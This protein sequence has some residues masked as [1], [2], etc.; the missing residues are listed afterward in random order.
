MLDL[1]DLDG[2]IG[3]ILNGIDANDFSGRSVSSA[4]DVNGDGYDDLIIGARNADPDG[5]SEAGET[6]LIYGGASAPGTGGALD[7][8]DLD[9]TNGFILTGI[10]DDDQ[11]GQSVSSAGDV[12]GDGYDDLI[13]GAFRADP[14]GDNDAGET[15]VIYGGA[16]GTESLTPVTAQGTAA[17][18]NFTGNAGADSFTAIAT[19]DVV[20]GGAGDDRISVTALDFAAIDGGTGQDTLVLAGADLSL[21]LREPGNGGVDSVEVID[22]SGAGGNTLVLDAQAVFDLTEER[23]GGIATLDVLGDANDTVEL[24]VANFTSSG[25]ETEDGTTYNVYQGGNAE[26]RVQTGVQVQ[27]AAAPVFTSDASAGVAENQRLAYTAVA[28]DADG[29]TLSYGL[30]G[31]DAALFTIDSTTGVVS[32]ITAPD[33]GN[34]GDAGGDNVY[35]ITVTASDG[36]H[37]TDQTVAITVTDVYELIDLS[38]LDGT[39]GFILNGID[40]GD[41][42]GYSVSSAG[43]V[44]GDGYDDLIIGARNADPNGDRDAGETYVIYGGASAPGTNGVLD[45]SDLDGTD[46][47]ILNGIYTFGNSGDSVSSAGDVNG[48]GY[49]DLI[50]QAARD[51][52]TYVVYGGANAPGTRGVLDLSALDGTN[53]FIL[54]GINAGMFPRRSVSSAGDVN[55]DGYDDLLIGASEADPNGQSSGETY[56][57][58]GRASGPGT[59]GV[60]DLSDL[61]GTNG[62]IL[63][64][65][66]AN[67][68]SGISVSSAGD[69]NGD[70]YD[71]LIIGAIGADPNGESS[72][73]TYIVYGGA[74]APGTGGVLELSDLD[75]T[76]GFTLNGI[77]Q[78][79]GSGRSV[80]STG[81][82]N[83][84]GYDDLIIGANG[85]DP[86]G[87]GSGETYVVYG[88]ASAPGTNGVLELSDLD[89]TNGFILTGIDAGDFSGSSISSAGDVNGDGYDDLIIGARNADPNGNNSGETYVVYGGASAPGTDGVL[90]LSMLNGSNG[91]ILNGIDAN[92]YSGRSVSSAGDVNGDGYDDLI[93]GARHADPNGRSSGET[94]VIYGGATGTESLTPVTAQGTAAADNFTGNAGADSFTAIATNDVV[95]GGAGDDRISVTALDFAAIDG[96][97]GQDTLVLDGAGLSLDLTGA[98]HAGVDSV[99]VFDLSGTGANTLLLDAQAVFDLTEERDGGIA[100]LDV[101]GDADDTVELTGGSFTANGTATEDGT[102]YNVYQGG[103]A[104]VRVQTG[105]QVQIAAAPVFTSDATAR[106]AENQTVAYEAQATDADSDTLSYSLYGTDAALFTIDPTTGVVSF[107]TAPDF[108]NPGDAGGDNVYDITVTASDGTNS[109]DQTVTITVTN[110]Y[111][112]VPLFSFSVLDGTNGFILNGIDAGDQS[113]RSVS[114]AGDVNGDGYDDLIIGAHRAGPNGDFGAGETYVVYGGA[115]APGTGGRFNLSTLNGTNGFI[116]NGI[117][118]GD[119]SGWSVSS[120]GDV[121]GDGY[122]DLI[123]GASYADP[124]GDRYAGETYVIYGGASAPGT[125]GRFNLSMLNGTNGFILNGIDRFD[126]SGWSVSSA[127]DVNG[128]GYDDLIIGGNWLAD[129]NGDISAGETYIVYGG[130]SAPGT[131]GVLDLG[132]L[133]GTDGFILNGIDDYDASGGSVSSAGDV[134][135]DGYDDLIIG[136]RYADPNGDNSAG[137]TYVVYGGA[138]APGT[139]GRF[140]LSTLNGTNGFILNGIDAFDG[141]GYSVS[142]AGDVNGDGYDDLIIGASSA[143][144]NGDSSAGETYIV[145]GGASAP[146]TGGRFNLSTLNG[147]NGFILNGIDAGDDSGWSVSS[148]GDVNGDGYDDLIIGARTADPNGDNA[149]GET[150]VVYGGASAP[151]TNGVLDLSD[152]DGT[153]GFIL[154]GIDR[155]DQ[156]GRSVSSAG[157]VNGDGYDDLIIGALGA[158]PN[159]ANPIGAILIGSRYVGE[160]YVIYGGATGIKSLTPVTAQGTAAA[161]NFT[162]NAGADSFT[163]IATNDVVRG[164]AGDDRISVTAL[165]FAAID[166]GTGQDT[167]LLD[168]AGLSLDLREP[169]NGRVDSVEVIDLSGA[170]GNTLLLDAQAVFD[171]TEE[172]AG[173]IATLDVLGDGDDTVVLARDNFIFDSTETEAGTT[174]TVYR[175]DNAEVRVA[176]GVEVQNPVATIDL[177][178]LNGTNGFILN[179]IDADDRSGW[180]VSSAGDVNGDGY[181]DLIIGARTA[182]PNG[183]DSGESYVVYGGASAP[184]EDGVLDLSDLDGTNGFILNGIDAGDRS[185]WSVSSAGDVNGDGYDDLIIGAYVAD[186]NGD[187]NAGETYVIYGGASAPGTGGRLNLSTLDGTDGFILNGIDADDR[188]GWSVSSAGDVNGDGYDDLIIG[189]SYADPNGDRSGE[190]YVVYGGASA[191]GTDGV[192]DLGALDGSGG[193]IL[194]GID[195]VDISGNSVSSAGDVNGDG[196]DDLIIG[197]NGADPNGDNAAGET[198]VVYGGA[199]APGTNG[200]LDLSDLDGTNGFIFN[201]IDAGDNSGRSVS[202]A[203][204]VNGDGYDDLIMGARWADPNGDNGAGETYVVYGGASAPGTNGA[205]DLSDLDGTNGFILNGIDARD[206]S[207]FSVSSAGDI[208]GDGYDDLI[209]GAYEADPGGDSDAGETYLV[210]GGANAPGTGGVLD[211]SDL[212]G[213][214]GFILSGIDGGDQSGRSVSSA[215]DVNGDGYDDLIIGARRA[216]PNGNREAGESYVVYGGATGTESLTP[217]TAQGTAAA[218]NFTGNAGA[219]SFTAIATDD[220]VRGGAGDDRI[221]VTALDFAAIDGGTGQD[222]L[223]LDGAGLSLDL[224]GAGHAGVDSVEVFD[225]SGTGANNLVLDAQAVFDLTEERAGGIATLDVLGDADDRVEL[226]GANSTSSGT[227]TED[228]TTYNVY[229]DGNAEVRVQTGVQVHIQAAPVFT[230]DAT[231][232]VAENQTVAYEA[233]ATDAD[234]DPLSYSLSGT[235]AALFTIDPAT[236]VVSF[237]TAPDF[238]NPGDAGGDNVYDITVT[239]SDGT[240]STDQTVAITVTNV[241]DLVPLFSLSVLDGTNGFILNG[242]DAGDQSG[243]SVSSAGD[244]NGDGYDDLIIGANGADPNGGGSGETYVVYGGASAPGTNGVLDLSDLDGTNGFILTGIDA[245]DFSG[246]SISSAGDVNG[247]GYDDLII[248]ARGASPNEILLA[249]ETYVV[250]GGANAPGTDGV[251]DLGALDGSGGFILNGI[252]GLDYSGGSVSSAGDVNGDGYDDLIIGAY[253]ADPN[254]GSSGETYVV[255]GG[256]SAPGTDGVLDLGALDGTNGFTLNGIDGYGYSGFSVSSA[257]DVNGDGYDDLIIGANGADP[258]GGGSGET[259]VVY[260]GA[261]APGTGGGFNLSTLDGTNGFILNGIDAGDN[262]GRSV[263]SAGDVNGDGYDDL[264]IG[265]IYADPNGDRSGE[266]YVVYGGASAPGTGGRLNLSTLDGTDGFILNGIDAL[267]F[268]G[269]SV[270]SAGDVNGDGY[271]DLIIGAYLADPNGDR[272]GETYVV[273]GGA[274][275]PGT[276]GVLDLSDLDGTNGFILNG[277]DADDRSGHFVSSAGDVNG[278]GYDDL[279]IGAPSADPN[280]DNDA[281]ETY[282]IYGGATGTESLTPVTAQGTVAADNF[283]GNAGADS[284][285]AIATNDVVRGAAGDDRISVTALDFAAID[286]GT[287]QDTLVLAGADLSLDLRE[288]GNGGVDSVEVIDLSGAGGN[289]LVL[290]AQAVFDLTEERA[291]GIATLDVLGDADDRVRLA[292]SADQLFALTG[293][294]TEDGVT[295]SVYRDGNAEVRVETGVQVQ[296]AAAP[297]FTSEASASV[298]ENQTVAYEAQATDADSDTLSYSLSGTDA[299]LFTIDPATGVVSFITAPDFENPGDAGGDNVYDI[300]VTASDGTNSTDQTVAITVTN[301]YDLV[302]LFSLSVLDGTNGFI[303]NGIDAGDQSGRSVSSAGDIN[304]DGYDDLIIGANGADPNGGGSGETYVVYGGASAPGTNGV[305]DLSDLDGTNGFILNGID[306]EDFSGSSISSAGDVNGDGYDDLIIGARGASPNEIHLAGETY[307]VYG[308]ANAPGTDGVLDLGALD[309]SGGFILNGIDGLDYSGGSVSSAGDVNGDGYDDLIIGAYDADPNGGSSGETYVV[310]GGASAPGTDGVLDLGALD[311]T[312]GFTLNGIDG[313]DYSG[314]SVSSAGDVNGDG[315]DD[316]II[317]ARTAD[318]NGDR[319][320]GETYVVYGGASAPG[321]GGRFNLSTLNGTNG[322]ILNGIDAGD[323]SGRSVSSAG[324]VNGDGYDDLII[325]AIYAD[326]NGDS[327]SGETYVVYGG[328]SAPGTG[329]RLNLSTLDGTDGFILNGIDALDFSGNS[330][331]S[332]G[333]VNGDGYDDL[334]IG[335]NEADPNGDRS[336]ETYVVYGGASTPGT[337]GVLDLSDL[338]GTNG[339]ILNGIDADDRSGHFVSSAGDVNGDGYDDL[340][341]GA[342]RADPNGN[343][344][345]GETY[346]I[347]GGATGTESLTP[348][349]AQGTAPPIISPAMPARTVLLRL[350]RMMWCAAAPAMTGSAS[351]RSTLRRLMAAR[352]R[353]PWCWPAQTCPSTCGNPAMGAWTVW[354]SL[355]CPAPVATRWCWT[356]RPCST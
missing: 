49:D 211:L 173:G 214:N 130:A 18:D 12:N 91:F 182:D 79:D 52:I 267:D 289:T 134:N 122:D 13:I 150:Y 276:N 73:E 217:V 106:V 174:W 260:G 204:D 9:G 165:D 213:T 68:H 280:G 258:N 345:A 131:D 309:G 114:S 295:Y 293:Q 292:Q 348:V 113:G 332:A 15:Y 296:I 243:R 323:N 310:Y 75:G 266:T 318:P 157:D 279:I 330:V 108:E 198:Y 306:A 55:G 74:S 274:S 24:T 86:N 304:G 206:F 115:S 326:P 129:P 45:L 140:N 66:D 78:F 191:P 281:G 10:D 8:S 96:G 291:G 327:R 71:D 255:Y 28:T 159:G 97:T 298:V 242:I 40:A 111:D 169:G 144:P 44:N 337:N 247:D 163:A 116:L 205:L 273:Y 300:T 178:L 61:D 90:D 197:A 11:S 319:G 268:S 322:F 354:K 256:A 139:G 343:S 137:E 19:N 230:S 170:G 133:N 331:S 88:G 138:S 145:Y 215:G 190:T 120:A 67:D 252:D 316:L 270:S 265:A 229:Q 172:R 154:N 333:D 251:L 123:I 196:Y 158:N 32:F 176:T 46:G 223:V 80:S 329:G 271:D 227:E 48:D 148:A 76:N 236:G 62:F 347:Y 101:L 60:L 185:G 109:T 54:N 16:T 192:L 146:G 2:T 272:S 207:G 34:P 89:G 222:T 308:G 104:E 162:G 107:I 160:T 161:D 21:D 263:S 264:I 299:V 315:Y 238:E 212:D 349:T 6:Y 126:R 317:G 334:I 77:D 164:S 193:F 33:F 351:P 325:G 83:G 321:T 341:I 20:R 5:D 47:F 253:E 23:A 167:L 221:S 14:D 307:V 92:D 285:T 237:I 72:G 305:L 41:E 228:G 168:G 356:R 184:G 203:G 311:G 195:A 320:S 98:G 233:Q 246:S 302:P 231:A 155:F 180:S 171:L 39:N 277:I 254:G 201:G 94:Y 219:D 153:N 340:I 216:G 27:I 183:T 336:G 112:L 224:T 166:G 105:V 102:T 249:G 100:S 335:A 132:A 220:V 64:G 202:S 117:D 218:D 143:G 127:G 141:S 177:S 290:D 42:S 352:A 199:S 245:G 324:D 294:E 226:A 286:G 269:N 244:I 4:G 240:N 232:R 149:A 124:N 342:Y 7:L 338:D 99:E 262:S 57:V 248:G 288:P 81:D 278:D 261:S 135:G 353:T 175:A 339:F 87:G 283:T 118:A 136:A 152:L 355:T 259:Y 225:L 51:P 297:V 275:T 95:R 257:G 250:Y 31:T 3:F 156:S 125:G 241:Y 17:A 208:N 103:N 200:V 63:N 350:P 37:S 188:S 22:L 303:L 314:F 38:T 93:I 312:N 328:A 82:V 128:D 30:S 119:R 346:V 65:I 287:G 194:N 121:N 142:S 313:Y 1:S 284:F 70:G 50:I 53:G 239:A 69:V 234:S 25:T 186:P 58:Y 110:I 282:V 210:Y 59:G 85:A 344:D 209:I 26:V 147:T 301:V 181:D 43:D 189:A 235:D 56:V 179:G 84:D 35:D 36:T 187:S 29:D 151:G